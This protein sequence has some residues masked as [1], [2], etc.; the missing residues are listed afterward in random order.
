M[1]D[2]ELFF[3]CIGGLG[4]IVLCV[5][6]YMIAKDKDATKRINRFESAIEAIAKEIYKIQKTQQKIQESQESAEFLGGDALQSGINDKIIDLNKKAMVLEENLKDLRNYFDEKY[7]GLENRMREYSS[8]SFSGGDIDEKKIIDMFQNGFSI[9][10]IA[11]ELRIGRG[12][13]EFT[14]KLANIK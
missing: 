12:E 3:I 6:G 8:L 1:I 9:D 7:I 2:E 13:V 14:L 4:F 5:L 10:S 11:K